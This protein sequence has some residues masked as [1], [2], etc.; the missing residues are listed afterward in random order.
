[1][2]RCRQEAATTPYFSA[3]FELV[4]KRQNLARSFF[5]LVLAV[6]QCKTLQ[7]LKRCS[8]YHT[9]LRQLNRKRLMITATS[10]LHFGKI[11]HLSYLTELLFLSKWECTLQSKS[12]SSQNIVLRNGTLTT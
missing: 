3:Q 8:D 11:E 10:K 5:T 9:I 1:V 6:S 7:L 12:P 2:G 4:P